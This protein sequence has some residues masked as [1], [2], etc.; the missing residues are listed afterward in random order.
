M[1]LALKYLFFAFMNWTDNHI[2]HPLWNI[3]P[4]LDDEEDSYFWERW[5]WKFCIW[6]SNG[7]VSAADQIAKDDKTYELP[8]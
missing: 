1:K 8:F 5:A 2:V 3:L 6:S 4:Q 7:L